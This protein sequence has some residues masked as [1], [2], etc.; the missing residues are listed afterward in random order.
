VPDLR[1]SIAWIFEEPNWVRTYVIGVV[2]GLIPIAFFMPMGYT[3]LVLRD[4]AEGQPPR[5]RDWDG[6]WGRTFVLGLKAA[7]LALC[8]LLPFLLIGLIVAL[9]AGVFSGNPALAVL[10]IFYAVILMIGFSLVAPLAFTRMVLHDSVMAGLALVE[11]LEAL[12]RAGP[13]YYAVWGITLGVFVAF[14]ILS[15]IPILGTIMSIVGGFGLSLWWSTVWG[16]VC[17]PILRPPAETAPAPP[18]PIA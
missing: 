5:L 4:A 7:L 11:I 3:L 17:G 16:A 12:R 14:G 2:L 18:V 6:L 1:A 10:A 9:G 15:E 8:Y 13:G